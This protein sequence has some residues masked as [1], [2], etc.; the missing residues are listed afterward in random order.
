MLRGGL[1]M[2]N[3]D[4]Q[5]DWIEKYLGDWQSTPLGESVCEGASI[6]DFLRREN[7]P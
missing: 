7:P 3:L 6:E 4:C 2:A 5:L 1:V